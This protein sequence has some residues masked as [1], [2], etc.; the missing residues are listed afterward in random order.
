M[1]T[2]LN[3]YIRK[4]IFLNIIMV[5]I[6]LMSLSS[7][8][9]LID[10]LRKIGEHNYSFYGIVM[11]LVLS[12]P[13][14]FELFLPIATL[15][16]GLLGLGLLETYNELIIIQVFGISKLQIAIS[17]IKAIIPILLCGVIFSEWIL[18]YSEKILCVHR[19]YIQRDIDVVLKKSERLLWYADNNCF[20]YIERILT[21]SELSGVTI[22]YFDKDKKLIKILFVECALFINNVWNFFNINELDF[23]KEIC[24]N[25][26][27][28]S[29]IEYRCVLTPYTLSILL[30]HPSIL[31]I[32]KLYHCVK[33][34]NK[35]GQNSKYYQL[36]LWNKILSPF[37]GFVMMIM[38]IS[39]TF[40]PLCQ[41]KVSIRLC[42]GAI[43]GFMFYIL[44]QIFSILSIKYIVFPIIG[45]MLSAVIF[46][47][48]SIIIIWRYY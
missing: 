6:V 43:I 29:H 30:K 21:Y 2:I 36:I 15:L 33:Y 32:S 20:F 4:I 22:Y 13:K 23:S 5:F 8:I 3:D 45:S 27:K 44:N 11:C 24:V 19:N 35:V 18:P 14:D 39:C 7:I 25:K 34:L 38:A 46:L 10:E 17:V 1:C 31:S 48:I 42:F 40:G 12:L 37:F 9:R 26:R 28:I 47:I 16:G 41:K